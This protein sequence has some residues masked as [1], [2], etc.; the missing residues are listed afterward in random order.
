MQDRAFARL[1]QSSM[2]E[3]II[4]FFRF[5]NCL[6]LHFLGTFN[7]LGR[8]FAVPLIRLS[9]NSAFQ[10]LLQSICRQQEILSTSLES[11]RLNERR[12]QTLCS[13]LIFFYCTKIVFILYTYFYFIYTYKLSRSHSRNAQLQGRDSSQAWQRRRQIYCTYLWKLSPKLAVVLFY[14]SSDLVNDIFSITS[15]RTRKAFIS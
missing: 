1:T 8:S 14:N 12:F 3:Q 9:V 10:A 6:Y 13:F 7:D 15:H 5:L 2:Y 4:F 11:T